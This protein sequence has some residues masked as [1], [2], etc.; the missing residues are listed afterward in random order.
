MIGATIERTSIRETP[1]GV[2]VR[3]LAANT[4]VAYIED[5]GSWY[6][7]TAVDGYAQSGYINAR[8]VKAS[9]VVTPPPVD[10]PI[11]PLPPV[12]VTGAV[13][14]IVVRDDGK[15]SLDGLGYE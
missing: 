15:I 14:T 9:A 8:S 4:Q 13:H 3:S 12:T 1:G 2:V 11:D 5:I 10:P 7:V 6:K